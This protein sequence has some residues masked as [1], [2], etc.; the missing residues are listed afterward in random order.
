MKFRIAGLCAP[1]V[2]AVF[3]IVL[4]PSAVLADA[5]PSNHGHHYH[6]GWVHHHSPPPAP[7]PL[8]QPGGG[9]T[10]TGPTNSIV[11]VVVP[12]NVAPANVAPQALQAPTVVPPETPVL[13]PPDV[14]TTA[15]PILAARNLWL[16][17]ILL[18]TVVA[19]NVTLAVLAAGRG[20]HLAI[21]RALAPVGIRV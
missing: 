15:Q 4:T 12:A 5:N 19:V 2:A 11:A 10:T 7:Q 14:V 6:F 9:T 17:A 1:F 18:A 16:V 8:P 3:A 21:K 13:G 20:G